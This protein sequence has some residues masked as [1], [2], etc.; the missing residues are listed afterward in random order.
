MTNSIVNTK[1]HIYWAS[2][3]LESYMLKTKRLDEL[4]NAV[5]FLDEGGA[6]SSFNINPSTATPQKVNSNH[7][8]NSL[9]YNTKMKIP[10]DIIADALRK[11]L[12]D[13][14]KEFENIS[15]NTEILLRILN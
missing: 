5:V 7:L 4:R 15:A 14:E 13:L 3:K 1:N 8:T 6:I 10:G 2:Q 9:L 12:A 11:E